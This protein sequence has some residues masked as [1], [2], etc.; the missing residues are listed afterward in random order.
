M[1]AVKAQSR[2]AEDDAF[3]ALRTVRDRASA[4]GVDP[5][6]VG[7]TGFSAGG[8]LTIRRDDTTRHVIR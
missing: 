4:W 5:E 2:V 3:Q 1:D 6:R 8:L 7:M